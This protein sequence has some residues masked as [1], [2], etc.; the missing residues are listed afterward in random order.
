M[1]R[2][3]L[4]GKLA[5]RSHQLSLSD[6]ELSVK[7]ILDTLSARIAAG[8]R[9]EIRDFGAFSIHVRPPRTGRNPKTGERVEVSVKATP[10]F[11]PGLE[12]RERVKKLA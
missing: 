12:L 5:Q 1:T 10:H 7:C 9:V 11:K 3:E 4:I 8:D 6:A 2:S